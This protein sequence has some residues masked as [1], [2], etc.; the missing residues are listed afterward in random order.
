MAKADMEAINNFLT[1][2][3]LPEE[4]VRETLLSLRGRY[5]EPWRHYHTFEHPKELF[6]ILFAHRGIVKDPL[7]VGWAIMYHDAIY[8]PTSAAGRNE[9]LSAQLA[10]Y[11]LMALNYKS[12]AKVV[13]R[14]TRSTAEH[15]VDDEDDDLNFFLDADLAILGASTERYDRYAEDIRLEYVHHVPQKQYQLGRIA[16]L[17]GL[18]IRA[19]GD[20]LFRTE[21]FRT[22]YEARAQENIVREIDKLKAMS[23]AYE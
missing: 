20:G 7:A 6:D 2:S 18:A 5:Q 8:D 17:Q 19:E 15:T 12:V 22:S 23:G 4:S 10:E 9:E 14:Y 11:E 16:L 13:A 1:T 3:G 21:L